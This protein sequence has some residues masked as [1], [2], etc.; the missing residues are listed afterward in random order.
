VAEC[1]EQPPA[2]DRAHNS[3]DEIEQ[4]SFA[5]LVDDF[6]ADKSREKP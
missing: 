6:A 5:A 3:E 2:D 1:V 4:Q